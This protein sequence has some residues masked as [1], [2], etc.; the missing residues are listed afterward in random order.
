MWICVRKSH[1]SCTVSELCLWGGLGNKHTCQIEQGSKVGGLFSKDYIKSERTYPFLLCRSV[2]LRL[3]SAA[4]RHRETQIDCSEKE[5][6][7]GCSLCLFS[8]CSAAKH[9]D[10]HL[11]ASADV[12]HSPD[13]GMA[14]LFYPEVSAEK[15]FITLFLGKAEAANYPELTQA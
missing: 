15:I 4:L 14:H 5:N 12:S 9:N 8:L 7:G 1:R 6:K 10:T 13:C 2:C 11:H 3:R